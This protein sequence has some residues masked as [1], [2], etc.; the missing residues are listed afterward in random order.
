VTGEDLLDVPLPIRN[1]L[2]EA[3][4]VGDFERALSVIKNHL[5]DARR[6]SDRERVFSVG[7]IVLDSFCLEIG[8]KIQQSRVSHRRRP[9]WLK[10]TPP[11]VYIASR[12]YVT[13]GHTPLIGDFIQAAGRPA[14][15]FITNLY[16]DFDD[17]PVDILRRVGLDESLVAVAPKSG[18]VDKLCWLLDRLNDAHTS[19]IFLFNH[20]DDCVAVAACQRHV[21]REVTFVH[22]AD[23]SA[24]IGAFLPFSRHIDLTPYSFS[25]CAH[26][27]RKSDH[28]LLP[29][30][31][32][33]L[34]A[35]SFSVR[36]RGARPLVT[37]ASGSASKFSLAY[38]P[39]YVD[40][41]SELLAATD[42]R[43]VHIG[44]L[45]PNYLE[46]FHSTLAEKH[47]W[48]DRLVHIPHVPSVWMSMEAFAVDLY[49]GSF[50]VRGA[51]TSVEV[52]GSA[53]PAL[54]HVE[55]DETFFHDTHMRY[56]E[57]MTWRSADELIG[58]V[59]AM[60]DVLLRSQ[61]IFARRHYERQ[62]HPSILA[63]RLRS[64]WE[65]KT[66]CNL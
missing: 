57:A 19:R 29:L 33:D 44:P 7:S 25:R 22:H 16:N 28:C 5:A 40:V 42:G 52:M 49:I 15:L 55:S 62:H 1:S 61:S 18:L 32:E 26:G 8:E 4:D 14:R 12:L 65:S 41:V 23:R 10:F 37:A 60:D 58:I 36:P 3:I 31:A 13:G 64:T 48:Q 30:V 35:R 38:S 54:W 27:R 51:R 43:H 59:R 6:K 9:R 17:V 63:S 39:S 20:A 46:R 45:L 2:R 50:P 53:T 34:G 24:S 11:D 21:K 47:V 66:A 56:P